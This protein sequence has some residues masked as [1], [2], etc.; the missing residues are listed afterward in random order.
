MTI[1]TAETMAHI[2]SIR[3]LYLSLAYTVNLLELNRD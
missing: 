2:E 3:L 1:R